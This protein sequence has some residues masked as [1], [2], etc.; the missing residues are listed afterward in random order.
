MCCEY[1][2]YICSLEAFCVSGF[3]MSEISESLWISKFWVVGRNGF[4]V[5]ERGVDGAEDGSGVV[6]PRNSGGVGRW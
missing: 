5:P 2:V 3:A 6:S 4:T 1:V